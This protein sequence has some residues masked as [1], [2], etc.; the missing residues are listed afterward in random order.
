MDERKALVNWGGWDG[1]EPDQCAQTVRQ[2]LEAEG[3][4]VDVEHDLG[5][6]ADA[7]RMAGYRL[8]VPIWTM[9][10]I[11]PEQSQG[12]R[13]AVKSGA[14]LA[15]FH[16]GMA[17]SFRMDTDYQYMVGGQWVAH[18][19]N[20][21]DYTVQIRDREHP[22]TRGIS[23]F[24]MHSEQYYMHVDPAVEVLATTT[25]GGVYDDWIDGVVMPVVWTKRFGAGRVFYSSLGHVNAD[26]QVPEAKEL[27]RRGMLWA[28]GLL[29]TR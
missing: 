26:L 22:I 4:A 28:S 10:Q 13:D 21:I 1:H 27:L 6:Y 5:F 12:L 16:G 20:V 17:D 9:E 7:Q 23:D 29:S 25:F 15:G 2:L 24:A 3:F 18:P 11:T 14:A 8:I 19:G